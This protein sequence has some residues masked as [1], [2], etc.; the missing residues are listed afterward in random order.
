MQLN[1][2][3]AIRKNHLLTLK[4]PILWRSATARDV[5]SW[6]AAHDVSFCSSMRSHDGGS[7]WSVGFG[8]WV[9]GCGLF[10]S[11]GSDN[12]R[13]EAMRTERRAVSCSLANWERWT[14][15]VA[16]ARPVRQE[17]RAHSNRK[18]L[19]PTS[20]AK[21]VR[22]RLRTPERK[23]VGVF[24][25][26]ETDGLAALNLGHCPHKPTEGIFLR[27]FQPAIWVE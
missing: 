25:A 1:T 5:S 16:A 15:S 9:C 10:V 27:N 8:V 22:T 13:L 21:N 20:H 11:T 23:G 6:C 24:N 14:R 18:M 12:G 4:V 26:S 17:R 2:H 3:N 19:K 7:I